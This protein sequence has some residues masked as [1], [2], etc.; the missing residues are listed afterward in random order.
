MT[1]DIR[2]D[3]D[4]ETDWE[5]YEEFK[6]VAIDDEVADNEE[7]LQPQSWGPKGNTKHKDISF[8]NRLHWLVTSNYMMPVMLVWFCLFEALFI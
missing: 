1:D 3:S 7:L 8:N 2:S 6:E 5:L 4:E